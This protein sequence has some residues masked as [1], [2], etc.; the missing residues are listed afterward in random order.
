MRPKIEVLVKKV[1]TFGPEVDLE[2]RDPYLTTGVL[3][4]GTGVNGAVGQLLADDADLDPTTPPNTNGRDDGVEPMLAF[5]YAFGNTFGLEYR[6]EPAGA[7]RTYARI[8]TEFPPALPTIAEVTADANDVI[9]LF[10]GTTDTSPVDPSHVYQELTPSFTLSVIDPVTGVPVNA[11]PPIYKTGALSVRKLLLNN[12]GFRS[13]VRK[14]W[15]NWTTRQ[16]VVVKG[17]DFSRSFIAKLFDDS[18]KG[19]SKNLNAATIDDVY[20]ETFMQYSNYDWFTL[21]GDVSNG[22]AA[23][24]GGIANTSKF[25]EFLYFPKPMTPTRP[26]GSG[27]VKSDSPY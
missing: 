18:I 2:G 6:N 3:V 22:V 19:D 20:A 16:L 14:A 21:M 11:G 23:T 25:P 12:I 9:S 13:A 7:E 4:K 10:P 17:T 15:S 27:V 8:W 24:P 1:K 26:G 5:K